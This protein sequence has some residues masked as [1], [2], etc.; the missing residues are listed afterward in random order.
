[1]REAAVVGI[2]DDVLGE[3]VKAYVVVDQR[4]SLNEKLIQRECQ[5]RLESF[6]V[7]KYIA[8]VTDLPRTDTGK[9]NKRAILAQPDT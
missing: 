7:P 3:A 2:P 9:I 4:L 1:V 8:I 6:M 5:S